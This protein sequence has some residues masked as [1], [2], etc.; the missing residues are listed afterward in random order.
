MTMF[1]Y[2]YPRGETWHRGVALMS[3]FEPFSHTRLRELRQEQLATKAR[4]HSQLGLDRE[5][6]RQLTTSIAQAVH[7]LSGRL[8]HPRG[9]ESRARQGA[10]RPALDS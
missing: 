6:E 2:A 3:L 9:G 8:A 4:R 5:T 1:L 7:A 10:G